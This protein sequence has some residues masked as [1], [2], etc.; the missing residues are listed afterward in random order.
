MKKERKIK[1][2]PPAA[3]HICSQKICHTPRR[4]R[5]KALWNYHHH[6]TRIQA[7]NLI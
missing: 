4:H 2:L 1:F 5:K 3:C 7:L 6:D